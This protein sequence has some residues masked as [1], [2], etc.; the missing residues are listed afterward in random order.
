MKKMMFLAGLM[1]AGLSVSAYADTPAGN[2]EVGISSAMAPH[3]TPSLASFLDKDRQLISEMIKLND[4]EDPDKLRKLTDI[5]L[6]LA[7]SVS[8]IDKRGFLGIFG[9]SRIYKNIERELERS[10]EVEN[11]MAR[12]NGWTCQDLFMSYY[13]LAGKVLE[14][15]RETLTAVLVVVD[16]RI[17]ALQN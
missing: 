6:A 2:T 13:N 17:A 7:A 1:A 10:P 14:I 4:K 16:R 5:K 9:K 8:E 3:L 12:W 11:C 15:H